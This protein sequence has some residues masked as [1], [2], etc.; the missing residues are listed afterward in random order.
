MKNSVFVLVVYLVDPSSDALREPLLSDFSK[1]EGVH[2]CLCEQWDWP[3]RRS[4][5]THIKGEVI[6]IDA[7]GFKPR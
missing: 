1:R 5:R 4:D 7:R 6:V 2:R 3:R